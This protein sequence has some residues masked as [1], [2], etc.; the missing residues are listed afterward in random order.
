M[1]QAKQRGTYE[2]R[3]AQGIAADEDAMAQYLKDKEQAVDYARQMIAYYLQQEE[4]AKIH[5]SYYNERL[6]AS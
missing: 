6:N 1:G 3:V 2:Q 4:N 5:G